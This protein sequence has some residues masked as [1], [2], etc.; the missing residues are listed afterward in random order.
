MHPFIHN[1]DNFPDN[2]L[3]LHMLSC[4]IQVLLQIPSVSSYMPICIVAS[5][6][7]YKIHKNIAML[8]V[9]RNPWESQSPISNVRAS[10]SKKLELFF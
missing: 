2:I 3:K 7:D 8:Q 1:A 4:F 6:S 10:P 5:K 9:K